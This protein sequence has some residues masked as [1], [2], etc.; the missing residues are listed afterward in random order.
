MLLYWLFNQN[1]RICVWMFNIPSLSQHKWH[2]TRKPGNIQWLF[3]P[4]IP[5]K[6]S[7]AAPAT[8]SVPYNVSYSPGCGPKE[9]ASLRG[10]CTVFQEHHW[11]WAKEPV[12]KASYDNDLQKI[13]ADSSIIYSWYKF[14]W[15]VMADVK[16][17]LSPTALLWMPQWNRYEHRGTTISTMSLRNFCSKTYSSDFYLFLF[18]PKEHVIDF[19]LD[20]LISSVV[21]VRGPFHSS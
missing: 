20:S 7:A 4:P 8:V 2:T 21:E 17:I 9:G 13:N 11:R 19:N 14:W 16:V 1:D 18:P 3:R 12:A 15:W 5:N 6:S 10:W